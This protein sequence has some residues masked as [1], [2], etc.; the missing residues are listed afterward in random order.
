MVLII[1]VQGDEVGWM[2]D[3]IQRNHRKGG[4]RG[5]SVPSTLAEQPARK[6]DENFV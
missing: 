6:G 1:N 5:P 3:F 2:E 4:D